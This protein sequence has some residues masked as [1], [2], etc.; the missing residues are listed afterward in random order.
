MFS[1]QARST[2][3]ASEIT[4]ELKLMNYLFTI[5]VVIIVGDCC[6]HYYCCCYY[7]VVVVVA[8]SHCGTDKVR[9]SRV[10][11][12]TAGIEHWLL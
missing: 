12:Q 11:Y 9:R 6:Y 10:C 5:I 1:N 4:N 8:G 2:E 3:S 7:V